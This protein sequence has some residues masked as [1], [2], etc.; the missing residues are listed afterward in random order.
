MTN[1]LTKPNRKP[2]IP[3]N[4]DPNENREW[5]KPLYLGLVVGSILLC[6]ILKL[7]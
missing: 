3:I 1:W 6:I 5:E 7:S 2:I 4:Y